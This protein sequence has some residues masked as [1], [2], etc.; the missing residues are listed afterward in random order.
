VKLSGLVSGLDTEAL[1]SKLMEIERRPVVLMESRQETLQERMDAWLSVNNALLSVKSAIDDLGSETFSARVVESADESVVTGTAT[2]SAGEAT[3]SVNV[4]FLAQAHK[5][6]SDQQADSTSALGL[7]GTFQVN[8]ASVTVAAADSLEDICDAINAADAGVTASIIENTLVITRNETGSTEIAFV[9]DGATDI[10]TQLGVLDASDAIKNELVAAKDAQFTVDGI[11]VTR[12]TNVVDDVIPGVTLTLQGTSADA[13]TVEVKADADSVVQA[14]NDF[15]QEYNEVLDEIAAALGEE[16][17]LRGDTTLV[18][19][20]WTLRELVADPVQ[21]LPAEMD[22][23]SQIGIT[24]YDRT[25]R[26]S[27][28]EDKLREAL[29]TDWEGVQSLFQDEAGGVAV[30]L[31]DFLENTTKS[32]GTILTR[33]DSLQERMDDLDE[34]I[35]RYEERLEVREKELVRQYTQMEVV[36]STLQ[37]QSAWLSSQL[38]SW[39]GQ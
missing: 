28:D 14:V 12:S 39:F 25:G 23:L 27:V 10:L 3:Y 8:G 9:D 29:D 2:S 17:D 21:G 33:T 15:V 37:N 31:G 7:S 20:Q 19:V 4:A 38:Q 1:I 18:R 6:A 35:T 16:G 13:M 5:V 36:L 26:L 34:Q 32:E 30:R 22:R 11:A 24:T